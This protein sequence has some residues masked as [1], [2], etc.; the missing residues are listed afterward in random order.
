[1][2][3][4]G[5]DEE[6]VLHG[7]RRVVG[8]E[9]EGVEVVPLALELGAFGHLPAHADEHVGHALLQQRQRMACSRGPAGGQSRHV[10]RLR[11]ELRRL[12]GLRDLR[13]FGGER[14]VHAGACAADE[15]ARRGLLIAG[16][17]T[18]ARVQLRERRLLG[19]VVVAHGLQSR[20]ID[21]GVDRGECRSDR[22][23]D[24]AFG[25][26]GGVRHGNSV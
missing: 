11:L 9:V 3:V 23:F 13:L 15:L 25:D 24:R 20:G 14:L 19:G 18:D 4:R 8:V 16:Q 10:D 22:R 21:R 12:L 26:F 6:R 1:M 17:R 7:A 5:L 2:G